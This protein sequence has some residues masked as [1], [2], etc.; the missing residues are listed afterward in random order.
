M[1]VPSDAG[2]SGVQ[3]RSSMISVLPPQGCN[4]F[5]WQKL[6]AL[7]NGEAKPS[8]AGHADDFPPSTHPA[9]SGGLNMENL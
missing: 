9:L 6:V 8:R 5:A 4:L 2:Q 1:E 7:L 3:S